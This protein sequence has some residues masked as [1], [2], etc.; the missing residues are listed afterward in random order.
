[1]LR[2]YPD[3]VNI[4]IEIRNEFVSE[5]AMSSNSDDSDDQSFQLKEDNPE[6]VTYSFLKTGKFLLY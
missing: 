3:L 5:A 6:N 4:I 1:M 2:S